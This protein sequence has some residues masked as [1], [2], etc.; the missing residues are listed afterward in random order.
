MRLGLSVLGP[1]LP[2][3]GLRCWRRRCNRVHWGGVCE[4]ANE[5]GDQD[6]EATARRPLVDARVVDNLAG[7]HHVDARRH[8]HVL[9][10]GRVDEAERCNHWVVL[11]QPQQ[12]RNVVLYPLYPVNTPSTPRGTGGRPNTKRSTQNGVRELYK[13]RHAPLSCMG[14]WK[15]RRQVGTRKPTCSGLCPSSLASSA[16][17]RRSMLRITGEF[18]RVQW[19]ESAG[20]KQCNWLAWIAACGG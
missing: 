17:G 13:S 15:R 3:L 7:R 10:L 1:G 5:L 4:H 2:V 14:R 16:A 8:P 6:V 9:A 19:C 12:D 20:T 18:R 11:V